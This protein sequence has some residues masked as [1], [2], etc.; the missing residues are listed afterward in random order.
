MER[1]LLISRF[2]REFPGVT[3]RMAARELD[4]DPEHLALDVM[5]VR[6][7]LACKQAYDESPDP[8]D[9]KL[10]PWRDSWLLSLV[11]KHTFESV[12]GR[13]GTAGGRVG[14]GTGSDPQ[15]P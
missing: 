1:L 6:Q 12:K 10:D 5:D 9:P 4:T 8:G 7:Y 3:P 2:C 13:K 14:R 15:A 11:E